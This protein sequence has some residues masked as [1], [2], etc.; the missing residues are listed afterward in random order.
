MHMHTT[1][2]I[3][4]ADDDDDMIK[5]LSQRCRQLG[6]RVVIAQTAFD[7]LMAIRTCLPDVACLDVDMP[8]GDGLSV[9]Q[10]L[11]TDQES[12]NLPVIILTG[13]KDAQT[14]HRCREL[15]AYYVAKGANIW[16]DVEQLLRDILKITPSSRSAASQS[17]PM[18][19]PEVATSMQWVDW[20]D[21][22]PNTDVVDQVGDAVT[23]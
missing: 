8:A 21:S 6:L 14:L 22:V 12:L 3:L 2:T 13:K 16:K 7:A 17:L 1:K 11:M 23:S 10:M 18:C 4:L 9:C 15:N 20:R 19:A 5:L